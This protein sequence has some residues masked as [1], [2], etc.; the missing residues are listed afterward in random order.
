V[1]EEMGFSHDNLLRDL[2]MSLALDYEVY[3][4]MFPFVFGD[5]VWGL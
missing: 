2:E 3:W 4:R 5:V 1:V